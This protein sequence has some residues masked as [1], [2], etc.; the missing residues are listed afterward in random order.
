MREFFRNRPVTSS[1]SVA[2]AG[3][4]NTPRGRVIVYPTNSVCNIGYK[5]VIDHLSATHHFEKD[6]H[7]ALICCDISEVDAY[8][9]E[10]NVNYVPL[11]KRQY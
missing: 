3:Y 8:E 2:S 6:K 9:K 7:F 4:L 5:N 1:D 10:R 11:L